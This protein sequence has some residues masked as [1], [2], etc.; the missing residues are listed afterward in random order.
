VRPW[1]SLGGQL[2]WTAVYLVGGGIALAEG[3]RRTALIGLVA[4]G[5]FLVLGL[6]AALRR[7]WLRRRCWRAS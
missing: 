4:G 5:V 2:I 3:D 1:V 6:V 7:R